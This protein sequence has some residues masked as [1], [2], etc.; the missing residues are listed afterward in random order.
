EFD[1]GRPL[2]SLRDARWRDI[3]D[4]EARAAARE[5]SALGRLPLAGRVLGPLSDF[6]HA[7]NRAGESSFRLSALIGGLE[8]HLAEVVLPQITHELP[9]MARDYGVDEATGKRI[10]DAVQEAFD[11][12]HGTLTPEDVAALI[13]REAPGQAEFAA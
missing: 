1:L 2:Q 8:R 5:R 11:N 6:N 10:A 4:A 7:L 13:L 9:R 3:I 12:P